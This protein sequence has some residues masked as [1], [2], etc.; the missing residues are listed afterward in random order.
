[1]GKDSKSTELIDMNENDGQIVLYQP[2]DSIRLEVKI[3]ENHNTVWLNTAQI[4]LLFNREDS[5]IRR[6][7][8]NIFKEYELEKDN[9]VHFLHVNGIKKPVKLSLKIII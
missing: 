9:N 5:V 1:M 6:H 2:E 8:I 7:I 4:A 3:D